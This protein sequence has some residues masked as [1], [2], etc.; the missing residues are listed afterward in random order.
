MAQ[1]IAKTT[2]ALHPHS[3]GG[4]KTSRKNEDTRDIT[5]NTDRSIHTATATTTNTLGCHQQRTVRRETAKGGGWEKQMRQDRR[6]DSGGGGQR[7]EDRGQTVLRRGQEGTRPTGTRR[8]RRS[9]GEEV[10]CLTSEVAILHR[11]CCSQLSL[12]CPLQCCTAARL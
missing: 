9:A 11:C 2:T 4:N 3:G 7:T 10:S 12:R 8:R 1:L 5:H 6:H